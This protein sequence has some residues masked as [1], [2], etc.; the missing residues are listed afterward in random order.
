M[1]YLDSAAIVKLVHAESESHALRQWLDERAEVGWVS[2]VLAEIESFRALARH[3]PE[4]V[5]RLPRVLDLIDLL[6]LDAGARIL[7][8]TVRPATVRSL[9]AIHLATALRVQPLTSFVTY[10]KRL[11][12]AARIAGLTVDAPA[13]H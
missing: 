3:V 11:A 4:A 10:D 2:S 1:I 13:S 5:S 9:D 8:Q 12:D 6:E 7:A